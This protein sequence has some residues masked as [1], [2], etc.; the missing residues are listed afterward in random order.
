LGRMILHTTTSSVGTA[1][2]DDPTK[3]SF[4]PQKVCKVTLGNGLTVDAGIDFAPEN[5]SL[6]DQ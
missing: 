6:T 3:K 1:Q 4:V 5:I 2:I